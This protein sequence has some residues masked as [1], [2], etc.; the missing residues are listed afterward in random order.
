M[1]IR[2]E[3]P[4]PPRPLS[5]ERQHLRASPSIRAL[6][7]FRAFLF[8]FETERVGAADALATLVVAVF[9]ETGCSPE[10]AEAACW[11]LLTHYQ[12]QTE[13]RPHG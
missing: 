10:Q 3:A 1:S 13:A 6:D 8:D 11:K 9:G 5:P 2:V 7:H 4:P 12:S